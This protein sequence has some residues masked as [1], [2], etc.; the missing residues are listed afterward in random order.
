LAAINR[1]FNDQFGFSNA[2][3]SAF[4]NNSNGFGFLPFYGGAPAYYPAYEEEPPGDT[5]QRTQQP[6]YVFP[7]PQQTPAASAAAAPAANQTPPPELGQLILV[8][9]DGQIVMAVAFT[10]RN[11]QLTYVT[12]EGTR[13]SFPVS[14]LDKDTTRQM[15]EANGT[16][17]SIPN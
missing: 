12:N 2:F 9:Q 4:V 3:N 1:G 13:R 16:S 6:I 5:A 15:N 17:V 14:E 7:S 11:G 8:R 10:I